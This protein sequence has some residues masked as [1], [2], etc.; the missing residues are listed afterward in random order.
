MRFAL[1]GGTRTGDR[2]Y[3]IKAGSGSGVARPPRLSQ[4]PRS[5]HMGT[6]STACVICHR[7]TGRPAYS[8]D[9][10]LVRSVARAKQAM[11]CVSCRLNR[12][13]T[14]RSIR[15][16]ASQ[17]KAR[18][19]IFVF[20][21]GHLC[22]VHR[23]IERRWGGA[24]P[25]AARGSAPCA[26]AFPHSTPVGPLPTNCLL[27]FDCRERFRWAGPDRDGGYEMGCAD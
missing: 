9:T 27:P 23:G 4:Y 5:F 13:A 3:L 2:S 18:I 24:R 21:Y 12:Q 17:R 22:F 1:Q 14:V 25:S 16:S 6:H 26:R 15:Y 20:R 19:G 8:C 10:L 11:N 7:S